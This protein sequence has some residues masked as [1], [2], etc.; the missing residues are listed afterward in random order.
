NFLF[1][2]K[3]EWIWID[4]ESALPG[5]RLFKNKAYLKNSKA[6]G[7]RP[8]FVDIDFGKLTTYL[9]QNNVISSRYPTLEDNVNK[10]RRHLREWKESEVA[11]F[12]ERQE[13]KSIF[14]KD[15]RARGKVT[16]QYLNAWRTEYNISKSTEDR[17]RRSPV[18][19][20]L[21][22]IFA[23]LLYLAIDNKFQNR[24]KED[25]FRRMED[26]G[27]IPQGYRQKLAGNYLLSKF[28]FKELHHWLIN[29]KA[30]FAYKEFGIFYLSE[31]IH[32][33]DSLERLSPTEK[34]KLE[35]STRESSAYLR[36]FG[37]HL[38]L[39]PFSLYT[40]TISIGGV[41]VTRS[42]EPLLIM[43]IMPF[44]RFIATV[45]VMVQERLKG[46]KIKMGVAL[47]VGSMPKIGI[48]GFPL[49]MYHTQREVFKL[50]SNASLSGMGRR[51]PIFG[52]V[53]STLE[54]WFIRRNPMNKGIKAKN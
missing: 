28:L 7:F 39:K 32:D 36:G 13:K 29:A 52:E 23:D 6:K 41:L 4:V 47:V 51:V 5:L 54:H 19:L 20:L 21:F 40:D 35:K 22:L 48:F 46:N 2:E 49:Q 17:I 11:I 30:R 37:Y 33:F 15:S 44:C 16:E 1:N 9:K 27:R 45:I 18:M 53:N 3:S 43:L 38:F 31:K 50:T 24:W 42:W 26:T 34:S 14:S 25:K 12:R 10:L 8:L